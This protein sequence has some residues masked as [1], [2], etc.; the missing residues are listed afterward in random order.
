MKR[1]IDSIAGLRP[2]SPNNREITLAHLA[3]AQ[4]AMKL[5][6]AGSA[7]GQKHQ[8][9]CFT[10]Q[11]VHQFKKKLAARLGL[12]DLAQSLNHAKLH[13]AA[14]MNGKASGL[15]NCDEKLVFKNYMDS[16][17]YRF[18]KARL[19]CAVRLS[20]VTAL[21]RS[22]QPKRRDT[23]HVALLNPIVTANPA[24]IDTDLT[25]SQHAIDPGLRNAFEA[26]E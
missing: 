24:A 4:L 12:A 11:S 10:I 1:R 20:T 7:L 17:G 15:I 6:Q 16:G 25:G 18:C 3:L 23:Q 2:A 9:G 22:R 19:D 5:G 8:S 14:P 26:G 13:A 21:H